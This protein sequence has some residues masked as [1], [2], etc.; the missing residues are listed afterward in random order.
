MTRDSDTNEINAGG[1]IEEGGPAPVITR[2]GM[3]GAD[4]RVRL[5]F[6]DA[7]GDHGLGVVMSLGLAAGDCRGCDAVA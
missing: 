2:S 4:I 3:E 1:L 5:R 6:V 7:E